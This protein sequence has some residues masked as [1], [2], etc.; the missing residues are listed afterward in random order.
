[1]AAA[2]DVI[3]YILITGPPGVGKTTLVRRV[4]DRLKQEFQASN[5]DFILKGFYTE[6]VRD[7]KSAQRIGFDI[8]DISQDRRAPL[9]SSIETPTTGA[10]RVGKY[11]VILNRF[12]PLALDCLA[13]DQEPVGGDQQ[14]SI[15]RLLVI[16]E[17]GKMESFSQSFCAQVE[18]LFDK[19]RYPNLA[20]LATVPV[21]KGQQ[22]PR[23]VNRVKNTV[24]NRLVTLTRENRE[25]LVEEVKEMVIKAMTD[26]K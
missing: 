25:R 21:D 9:A 11:S 13:I 22:L 5:N 20:I 16:D 7:P 8:V 1:M 15:Y 26:T 6:E 4:C 2:S 12:E 23:I 10:P 3:R 19:N 14:K 24:G 18:H 17:I